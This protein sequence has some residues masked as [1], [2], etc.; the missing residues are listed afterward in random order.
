MHGHKDELENVLA[1]LDYSFDVIGLSETRIKKNIKP[2]YQISL[3][4]YKYY[5]TPTEMECGGTLLY[6]Q[7]E[8]NS[9]PRHDLEKVVYKQKELESTFVEL[10]LPKMKN[11][12]CGCIYKHPYMDIN[13]FNECHMQPLLE[14]LSKETKT[15][16]I[17]GDFNINLLNINEDE[18]TTNFFDI[19]TSNLLIP[20]IIHPTRVTPTTKT[21][22][23]NI[24]SNSPNHR[25]SVSG[26]IRTFIS[27]HYAQFLQ[28]P[29][30]KLYTKNKKDRF[31][32]DMSKIGT[33]SFRNEISTIDWSN[34]LD[35]NSKDINKSFS[36][37]ESK[38]N[39]VIDKYAP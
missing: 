33:Q 39:E 23:D 16:F 18:N 20:F 17:M 21:V 1:E 11:I 6:I 28:I 3:P 35:Y 38:V 5:S 31:K 2:I 15:I 8:L 19:M 34:E 37:L 30:K 26:N 25:D 36:L 14:K 10:L 9:K 29:F 27:D 12:I 24:F 7:N 32:R 4:G 13:E 22:I